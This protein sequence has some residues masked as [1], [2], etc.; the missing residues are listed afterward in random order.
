[1]P[2]EIW[3]LKLNKK[4]GLFFSKCV[5]SSILQSSSNSQAVSQQPS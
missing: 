3:D 1:L 4:F 2:Q 5:Q